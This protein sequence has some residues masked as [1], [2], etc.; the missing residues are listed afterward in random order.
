[1]SSAGAL[2][3][4]AAGSS[5]SRSRPQARK[6]VADDAAYFAPGGHTSAINSSAAGGPSGGAG[7]AG[8]KRHAAERAEGE[9]RVKRKRV[10]AGAA[11]AGSAVANTAATRK[12]GDAYGEGKAILVDFGTL[13][14][15]VLYRYLTQ[16]DLIPH[17]YPAPWTADDP[18]PPSALEHSRH[19]S[20]GPSPPPQ[21]TPANRPRRD[22]PLNHGLLAGSGEMRRRSLRLAEDEGPPPRAAIMADVLELQ[23]V[24]A[25]VADR[26]FRE[27]L[28]ISGR[29]EVDTLAS[30]MCAVEKAKG[31]RGRH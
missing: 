31:V 18:P 29:E 16:F 5:G 2:S 19:A 11:A 12:E 24:L 7:G 22:V 30:F 3:A 20:R 21:N 17:I 9:P 14:S 8:T 6:K 4:Q 26:H 1:M 27:Q 13:P 10:D 15:S 25:G 23:A 28:S